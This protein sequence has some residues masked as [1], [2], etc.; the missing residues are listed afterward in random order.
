MARLPLTR[1][2]DVRTRADGAVDEYN[3]PTHTYGAWTSYLGEL[4][5]SSSSEQTVNR[6]TA[7]S[8]WLLWLPPD[9]VIDSDSQVR[10]D[11]QVGPDGVQVVFEVVG[12]PESVWHPWARRVDHIYARVKVVTG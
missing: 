12:A 11:G 3:N 1:P 2:V 7:I 9:A 5:Q 4:Q 10:V 6:D 8:D